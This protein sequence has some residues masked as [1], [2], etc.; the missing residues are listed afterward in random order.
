MG[1]DARSKYQAST[2]KQH[3]T[4]MNSRA[5]EL[6]GGLEPRWQQPH[7][8]QYKAV[9]A[10]VPV[11]LTYAQAAVQI[12]TNLGSQAASPPREPRGRAEAPTR[13][14]A[15][16]GPL[17]RRSPG[18]RTAGAARLRAGSPAPPAVQG[19]AKPSYQVRLAHWSRWSLSKCRASSCRQ[20]CATSSTRQYDIPVIMG[21]HN[22]Q[23]SIFLDNMHMGGMPHELDEGGA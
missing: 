22:A 15:G 9:R 1:H 7:Q 23:P 4:G 20:H 19:R 6:Q 10:S 16:S 21:L 17:R 18:T 14:T 13:T 3:H 12:S 2:P 5:E 8:L 11:R